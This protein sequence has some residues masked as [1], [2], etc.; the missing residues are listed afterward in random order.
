MNDVALQHQLDALDAFAFEIRKAIKA[1]GWSKATIIQLRVTRQA[2]GSI[3]LHIA[4]D[5]TIN[6]GESQLKYATSQL[7]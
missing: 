3:L 1:K 4:P 6:N 7:S 2:Q 5:T